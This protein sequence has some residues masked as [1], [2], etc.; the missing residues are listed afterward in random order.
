[1]AQVCAACYRGQR[2]SAADRLP[3]CNAALLCAETHADFEQPALVAGKLFGV[4][5]FFNLLKCVFSRIVALK[6]KDIHAV[7]VLHD[8]VGTPER[9]AVQPAHT[10]QAE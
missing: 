6:L 7:F 5:L 4:F 3:L 8:A 1:M 10:G 2:H 9:C